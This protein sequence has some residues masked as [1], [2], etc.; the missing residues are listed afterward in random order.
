MVKKFY[1]LKDDMERT[2]TLSLINTKFL[3]TYTDDTDKI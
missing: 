3:Q 2:L 1:V